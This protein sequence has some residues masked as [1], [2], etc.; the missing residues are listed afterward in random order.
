MKTGYWLGLSYLILFLGCLCV[1][2]ELQEDRSFFQQPNENDWPG[3]SLSEKQY[4]DAVKHFA[5]PKVCQHSW[6]W[7]LI[8]PRTFLL[9]GTHYQIIEAFGAISPNIH[10]THGYWGSG[11]AMFFHPYPSRERIRKEVESMAH[12]DCLYGV[13]P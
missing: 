3:D 5:D 10:V 1:E 8:G 12:D 6:R 4:E 7:A 13:I 2:G 11:V 9:K